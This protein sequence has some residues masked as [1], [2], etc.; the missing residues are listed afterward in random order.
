M[1]WKGEMGGSETSEEVVGMMQQEVLKP[2]FGQEQ[3]PGVK[4][5]P[6]PEAV[7]RDQR[8]VEWW[9]WTQVKS[10]TLGEDSRTFSG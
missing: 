4:L 5:E 9:A 7:L 6:I 2:E 10:H 8:E 1:D 3:Q